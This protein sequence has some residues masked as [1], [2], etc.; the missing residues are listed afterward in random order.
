[1]A[2]HIVKC[3]FCGEQFD[4]NKEP[5]VMATAR[6]YAHK[7]CAEKHEKEKTEEEQDKEKLEEYIKQLFNTDEISSKN[8]K[9]IEKFKKDNNFT[10]SGIMRSLIYFYEVKGNSIDKA[11]GSLGIVPWIYSEA[12]QYYYDLWLAQQR[13]EDKVLDDYKP[14]EIIITITPPERKIKKRKLFTFL[15][16][17][18]SDNI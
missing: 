8:K 14:N 11:H 9:Q 2:K 7:S 6:R 13:N 10:Y 18:E 15:D 5:F 16:S 3:F 4:T 17:K 12:Y 1:M